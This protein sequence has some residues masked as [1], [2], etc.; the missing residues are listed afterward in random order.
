MSR[1]GFIVVNKDKGYTSRDVVNLVCKYLGTKKVGH[2]GTLD[3]LAEGVLVVLVGKAT[4]VCELVTSSSKEYI[5]T[6]MLGVDTDTLDITGNVLR[7]EKVSVTRDLVLEVLKSF[8]GKMMQE[9]PKYSAVSV[10]GRRLYDYA[11]SNSYVDIPK[12]LINVY[13]IDLI[14]DLY[15]E[16][17]NVCF[18][19]RCLVSKGTYIRSLIRDIGIRLGVCACMKSL[20]RTK[21]GEFKI[22]DS[23]T[24][25]DISNNNYKLIK[26]ED[27]LSYI[28]RV[29]VSGDLEFRIRNGCSVVNTYNKDM[30]M[31]LSSSLELIGIYKESEDGMLRAWKMFL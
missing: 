6:A 7:R 30:V 28:D 24:L 3:P 18:K 14:G 19:F 22:E 2:T 4:K 29:V 1:D 21:Q 11:R 27:A 5:A 12:R 23:Y 16:D 26:I 8:V 15:E 17:G 9:V 20:V 25:M 10:N 13:E 31:F